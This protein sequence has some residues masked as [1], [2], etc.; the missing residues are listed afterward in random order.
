[1]TPEQDEI[2]AGQYADPPEGLIAEFHALESAMALGVILDDDGFDAESIRVVSAWQNTA[3]R[4][5]A[6]ATPCP[7]E[8]ATVR[9]WTWLVSGWDIDFSAIAEGAG[10]PE[11][12]ARDKVARLVTSRLI[13]P[14]GSM[15]KWLATTI[16]K[17]VKDRLVGDGKGKRPKG[18]RR[19][20]GD[21]DGS[22]SDA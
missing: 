11:H 22:A 14:D 8:L 2:D 1:M 16:N 15:S 9:A 5:R 13:Y 20:A 4:W 12:I 7:D 21:D 10:I 18:K 19:G 3:H 17:L 6:P